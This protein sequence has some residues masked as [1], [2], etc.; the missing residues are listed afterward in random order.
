M[1]NCVFLCKIYFTEVERIF[2]YICYMQKPT[3]Y[4]IQCALNAIGNNHYAIWYHAPDEYILYY[5]NCEKLAHYSC[6]DIKSVESLKFDVIK[7]INKDMIER[8]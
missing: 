3:K 5:N 1:E 8:L 6:E 7:R 2:Y 4:D